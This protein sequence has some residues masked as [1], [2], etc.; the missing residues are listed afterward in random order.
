MRFRYNLLKEFTHLLWSLSH[1]ILVYIFQPCHSPFIC[2]AAVT[3]TPLPSL[4]QQYWRGIIRSFEKTLIFTE[5][6]Q[7]LFKVYQK[8]RK[9]I[10]ENEKLLKRK[11][12]PLGK[13][14]PLNYSPE[15]LRG[16]NLLNPLIFWHQFAFIKITLGWRFFFITLSI[17]TLHRMQWLCSIIC[18]L[19]QNDALKERKTQTHDTP[20]KSHKIA[21]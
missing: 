6:W 16:Q 3:P 15:D 4:D 7:N 11:R 13:I 12:S 10:F 20:S 1:R 5:S 18:Y 8:S 19:V 17:K 21:P 2:Y 14:K 9:L